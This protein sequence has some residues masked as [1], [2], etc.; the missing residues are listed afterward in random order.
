LDDYRWNVLDAKCRFC[1]CTQIGDV[2]CEEVINGL[3]GSFKAKFDELCPSVKDC[4][5]G[6]ELKAAADVNNCDCAIFQCKV[7]DVANQSD[8]YKIGIIAVI[9]VIVAMV[10]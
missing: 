6:I 7:D 4:A 2:V 8:T 3:D 5:L 9:G 1:L 10:L